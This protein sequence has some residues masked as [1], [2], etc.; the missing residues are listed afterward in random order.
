MK[1]A[2]VFLQVIFILS[3]NTN[4]TSE[5]KNKD[6]SFPV[7]PGASDKDTSMVESE[8]NDDNLSGCYWKL[9][10]KD[11]FVLH[12][13]Q[14][15]AEV[16]GK[17]TFNNYQKD[18]S[19]GNVHGRIDG[20]IIK[21]LY[22]FQSEGIQSVM[23]VY[24]KKENGQLIRGLGPVEVKGDTA[25]FKNAKELQYKNDQTFTRVNCSDLPSK[26]K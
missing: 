4:N 12:L 24:F 9:I 25:S 5:E 1:Y 17:L 18:K 8:K 11:T 7:N 6:S 22:T 15:N 13:E 20:D 16:S 26:Y 2:F 19:S 23:E 3:C 14:S 21:L 10:Q